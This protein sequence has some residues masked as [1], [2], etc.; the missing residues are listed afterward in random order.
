MHGAC[1]ACHLFHVGGA[2]RLLQML[3]VNKGLER[4]HLSR[5]NITDAGAQLICNALQVCVCV[6]GGAGRGRG[7]GGNRGKR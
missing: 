2:R 1:P 5:T 6:G 4:L 7:L 3:A